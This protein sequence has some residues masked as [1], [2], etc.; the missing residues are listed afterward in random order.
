[1]ADP[2]VTDI[3]DS[4]PLED[5][6]ALALGRMM[7][8]I[9]GLE[10]L[11]R[12][13]LLG[14]LKPEAEK[15]QIIEA[16]V[17]TLSFQ[18]LRV[19]LLACARHSISDADSVS[20]LQRI[21]RSVARCEDRRNTLVHSFW[22][23]DALPDQMLRTKGGFAVSGRVRQDVEELAKPNE[24]QS[25]VREIDDLT[26]QLLAW[27]ASVV[28]GGLNIQSVELRIEKGPDGRPRPVLEI[29]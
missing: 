8:K 22:R 5:Q 14:L 16:L 4:L 27:W 21:L 25:V 24:I 18:R 2:H 19:A 23:Y 11:C 12:I 10:A 1:M 26:G 17:E 9:A 13:A 15:S 20:G 3:P 7:M 6:I 29:R 28:R